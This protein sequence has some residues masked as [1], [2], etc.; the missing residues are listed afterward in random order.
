MVYRS[1][2]SEP[3]HGEKMKLDKVA[4]AVLGAAIFTAGFAEP[5]PFV[6]AAGLAMIAHAFGLK[7]W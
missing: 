6:E 1:L 2:A 4:E 7:L 5:T 3:H